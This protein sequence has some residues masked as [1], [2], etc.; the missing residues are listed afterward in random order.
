MILI[1]D[2]LELHKNSIHDF[3]GAGGIRDRGLLESA[4][5]RPF[6]SLV[7][8]IYTLMYSVKQRL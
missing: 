1:D 5:A 7:V 4:I 8:K 2:I 3:G 6:Q